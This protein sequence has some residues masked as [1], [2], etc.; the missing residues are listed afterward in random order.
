MLTKS[1][2]EFNLNCL[3]FLGQVGLL[4]IKFDEGRGKFQVLQGHAEK[5]WPV[6]ALV[7]QIGV[8]CSGASLLSETFQ[9]DLMQVVRWF[10]MEVTL[11]Y[12][13]Q[14]SLCMGLWS[15]IRW[16]KVAE[17]LCNENF[18]CQ[19]AGIK[20][21]ERS[22]QTRRFQE[23]TWLEL[24]TMVLPLVFVPWFIVF[25]AGKIPATM[26]AKSSVG[27][28]VFF[29][30][31]LF[32]ELIG[33]VTCAAGVYWTVLNQILFM[34]RISCVITAQLTKLRYI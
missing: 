17:T 2:L 24:V 22:R 30:L 25:F 31:R 9:G 28:S 10:L 19:T 4:P 15:F 5:I 20:G 12:S 16:P 11:A 23:Y 3:R 7:S 33:F 6:F 21:V 14:I 26:K 8:A 27:A 32:S 34:S 29:Y 13:L 18:K 1:E